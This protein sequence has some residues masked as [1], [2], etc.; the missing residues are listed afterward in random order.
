MINSQDQKLLML[1]RT[2]A[3]ASVTELAKALH[4]SRST[5]QNRL[6]R[7]E[8]AGVI[9]G[10][11]VIL[12]GEYLDNQ[13]EAHVSIKVVQKLTARTNAALEDI[14]Q[15]TQLFSVSGEYD[16]IAIVQ[17]QSLEELS[18]VLDDIG[19]LEG[20]ERTNSAVVLETKFRR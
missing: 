3:R 16:L 17:A 8:K 6:A 11:S 19:N 18:R 5:V 2:N 15:V 10:Y 1:L 13:V 7:L 20:V 4:V 9:R 14:P 12:G